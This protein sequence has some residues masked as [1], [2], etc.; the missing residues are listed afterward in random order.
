MRVNMRAESNGDLWL[1]PRDI[2]ADLLEQITDE[3]PTP[4]FDQMIGL[5]IGTPWDSRYAVY[6]PVPL[7]PEVRP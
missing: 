5:D 7:P 3:G 6:R 2:V 4:V 1:Y